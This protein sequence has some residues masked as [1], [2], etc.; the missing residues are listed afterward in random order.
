MHAER[1]RLLFRLAAEKRPERLIWAIVAIALASFY[2]YEAYKE[3]RS[4]WGMV[5][6]FVGYGLSFLLSRK[7][8]FYENGIYFPQ[9]PSGGRTR[10]IAWPQIKRFYWDQDVLTIVPESS[11]LSGGIGGVPIIGGSVRIPTGRRV[12]VENLLSVV[13]DARV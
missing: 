7:V 8:G 13:P 12:Q 6:F 2:A 3:H 11:I 4:D 5:I 1:G 9:E 10:F